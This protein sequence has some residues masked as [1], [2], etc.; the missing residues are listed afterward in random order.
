MGR[1]LA[2]FMTVISFF[3]NLLGVY[4]SGLAEGINKDPRWF[5]VYPQYK[6]YI[7]KDGDTELPFRLLT[8]EKVEEN[9]TYPLVV[10]LHGSG[11]TGKNNR[12]HLQ[13]FFVNGLE[14]SG[15]DCY[16][17]LPQIED[18]WF[19]G[20]ENVDAILN[21]CIDD[22]LLTTYQ[23]DT[24]RI[25]IT[26]LSRGGSGVFWQ[27][28]HHQGKYAAALPVCGYFNLFDESIVSNYQP[29]ADIPMWIAHNSGDPTVPVSYSRKMYH[30]VLL[31][32]GTKI[33]YTEYDRDKHD[34][35]TA[36][37]SDQNVWAW[38]FAQRLGQ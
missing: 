37:Y 35:W 25:Y 22:Y 2:L 11:E 16:A 23:I 1:I 27:V 6:A 4:P 9:K 14:A 21:K 15:E 3:S 5:P 26:G 13:S 24:N 29:F 8:P 17:F 33:K 10:F 19:Y 32:C 18:D 7:Y 28:Y 31:L 20:D 30:S 38:M 36:F 34:A 12:D